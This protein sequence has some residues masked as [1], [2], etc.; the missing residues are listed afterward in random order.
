MLWTSTKTA[1][2]DAENCGEMPQRYSREARQKHAGRA[3]QCSSA[4]SPVDLKCW[5][6]AAVL[7][8]HYL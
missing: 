8:S 2:E 4:H 1:M 7:H 5:G 3:L 6:S